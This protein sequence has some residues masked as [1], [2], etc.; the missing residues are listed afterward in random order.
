MM[1][2]VFSETAVKAAVAT[3]IKETRKKLKK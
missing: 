2:F 1:D 3:E